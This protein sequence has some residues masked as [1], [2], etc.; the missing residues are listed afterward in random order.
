MASITSSGGI[1][2]RG[3]TSWTC[4][5]RCFSCR[6]SMCGDSGLSTVNESLAV[7]SEEAGLHGSHPKRGHRLSSMRMGTAELLRPTRNESPLT[8][9]PCP[10]GT[11]PGAAGI[12]LSL[13]RACRLRRIRRRILLPVSGAFA[14]GPARSRLV[15]GSYAAVKRSL[16]HVS[17][18]GDVEKK[19]G[20]EADR[21]LIGHDLEE[22][23]VPATL[24]LIALPDQGTDDV[25][26]RMGVERP[27][28]DH[29][30][31]LHLGQPGGNLLQGRLIG[32]QFLVGIRK[33]LRFRTEDFAGGG[34]F[35]LPDLGLGS[36]EEAAITPEGRAVGA[37]DFVT[38][39]GQ[40]GDEPTSPG[41]GVVGVTTED[42]D[43]SASC[44]VHAVRLHRQKANR[45]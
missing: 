35:L 21:L 11:K 4:A 39:S 43:S 5:K 10:P 29:D 30:V 26:I 8:S 27:V 7:S 1:I 16:L 37:N 33:E 19:I 24:T 15:P 17:N 20:S 31:R 42:D 34:C 9:A 14:R 38:L 6:G 23:K 44:P 13:P 36:P 45:G 25:M 22:V 2:P 3:A 28:S 41:F 32:D 18:R 12:P 40:R